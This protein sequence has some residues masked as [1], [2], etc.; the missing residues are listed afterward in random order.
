[1]SA[2]P[3]TIPLLKPRCTRSIAVALGGDAQASPNVA[4]HHIHPLG[5]ARQKPLVDTVLCR[6][7]T[8][9]L[10]IGQVEVGGSIVLYEDSVDTL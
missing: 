5:D 9:V 7:H 8:C 2:F 10:Q 6:K 3:R 1:M 4:L